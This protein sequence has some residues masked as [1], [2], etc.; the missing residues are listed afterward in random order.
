MC[1]LP[2]SFRHFCNQANAH[3]Q[4]VLLRLFVLSG[5]EYSTAHLRW[6][7]TVLCASHKSH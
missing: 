7:F 2:E 1:G 4:K 3:C 5:V 6:E